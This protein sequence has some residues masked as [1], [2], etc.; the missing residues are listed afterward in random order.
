VVDAP[1]AQLITASLGVG[2][3]L[4]AAIVTQ[5]L[6]RRSEIMRA[7]R[8]DDRRWHDE[9]FRTC[10]QFVLIL[11]KVEREVYSLASFLPEDDSAY[12]AAQIVGVTTSL[13]GTEHGPFLGSAENDELV[14]E[15][16]RELG[17]ETYDAMDEV[18]VE[19]GLLAS[20]EL[21]TKADE[22][23]EAVFTAMGA[24]EAIRS[25]HHAYD[26]ASALRRAR[27]DFQETARRVL[28]ASIKDE[29]R[30]RARTVPRIGQTTN[31]IEDG[32]PGR[33]R[34]EQ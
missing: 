15:R 34:V 26:S 25:H 3:T 7:K 19:L 22:A 33:P 28:G 30:P 6:L 13:L 8:E 24:I 4:S 5:V 27:E 14:R 29:R 16:I 31:Q 9:R 17:E 10:K 21:I 12:E 18:T 11:N 20:G 1:T 2:G 32:A 23:V